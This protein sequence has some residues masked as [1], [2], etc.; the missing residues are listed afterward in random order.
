MQQTEGRGAGLIINRKA[1][2]QTETASGNSDIT[3]CVGLWL[4]PGNKKRSREHYLAHLPKTLDMLKNKK[5]IF[6]YDDETILEFVKA[7]IDTPHFYAKK[8]QVTEMRAY[9]HI[10]RLIA[11]AKKFKIVEFGRLKAEKG[12]IHYKRDLMGSGE[13][14]YK[15][16]LTVWLSKV[17]IINEVA[18]KENPFNTSAFAWVDASISRFAVKPDSVNFIDVIP[19]SKIQMRG[20]GMRY[21]GKRI[22]FNASFILATIE[23]WRK[24]T[25]YYSEEFARAIDESYP[26]DE[27]TLLHKVSLKHPDLFEKIKSENKIHQGSASVTKAK[28]SDIFYSTVYLLI[29]SISHIGK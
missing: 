8:M 29:T 9:Q 15:F 13:D 5:V 24:L 20:S 2:H 4:V 28:V 7:S 21:R 3:Y 27:E 26:N 11:S 25:T 22:N 18:I 14:A 1:D 10:D 16:I 12:L 17:F 19:N 23:S 6:L